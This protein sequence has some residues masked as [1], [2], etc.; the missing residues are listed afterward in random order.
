MAVA[1][2]EFKMENF[3]LQLIDLEELNCRTM[4]GPVVCRTA[5]VL[6][7]RHLPITLREICPD[8]RESLSILAGSE[9]PPDRDQQANAT[10][11][12]GVL[13]GAVRLPLRTLH[14]ILAAG[15]RN[16]PLAYGSL[17]ENLITQG[18]TDDQIHVGDIYRV[19]PGLMT[20]T[21]PRKPLGAPSG[22]LLDRCYREPRL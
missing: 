1:V 7:P 5:R 13:K 18:W 21:V 8:T 4:V 16:T 12:G 9:K 15:A 11:H 2:L 22:R 14:G 10:N 3:G 20:V 17:G 19:V 6:K